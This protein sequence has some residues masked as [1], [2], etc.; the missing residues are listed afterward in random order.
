MVSKKGPPGGKGSDERRLR[1]WL[2]IVV[3]A[4][5]LVGVG[6]GSIVAARSGPR[7][8]LDA[9]AEE[10]KRVVIGWSQDARSMTQDADAATDDTGAEPESDPADLRP[11]TAAEDE[12][13]L[14]AS[15][16]VE[17]SAL[18]RAEGRKKKTGAMQ[19]R[20]RVQF[21][22]DGSPLLE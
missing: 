21:L 4:G 2:A 14:P 10:A 13:A 1:R 3:V 22:D 17:A 11:N 15:R 8:I 9:Y 7:K 5:G 20:T 16:K 12:K 6:V 19:K 18:A